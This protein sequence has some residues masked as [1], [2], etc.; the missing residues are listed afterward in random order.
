MIERKDPHPRRDPRSRTDPNSPTPSI[1]MSTGIDTDIR[2]EFY[3]PVDKRSRRDRTASSEADRPTGFR[4]DPRFRR[5]EAIRTDL[6]RLQRTEPVLNPSLPA[7]CP[8]AVPRFQNMIQPR[9]PRQSA[10]VLR[11]LQTFHLRVSMPR[12]PLYGIPRALELALL[13]SQSAGPVLRSNLAVIFIV[14]ALITLF[15]RLSANAV[16]VHDA[17]LAVGLTPALFLGF[18]ASQPMLGRI[19]GRTLR[20]A[21]IRVASA[22]ALGLCLR[23]LIDE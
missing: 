4:K 9:H 23:A 19:E 11:P 5:H 17:I 2:T 13:Y 22:A 8:N 20:V 21:V 10:L 3:G 18:W 6:H 7:F 16:H 12:P 15:G 1:E 14:G